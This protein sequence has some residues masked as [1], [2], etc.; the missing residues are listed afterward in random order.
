MTRKEF[1]NYLET[2]LIPDLIDSG[3]D[4]TAS[5]FAVAIRFIE[6]PGLD[7]VDQ[8]E[9]DDEIANLAY[10]YTDTDHATAIRNYAD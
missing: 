2:T 5:D 9:V 4:A 7:E 8:E 1:V 6:D 10:G 3:R